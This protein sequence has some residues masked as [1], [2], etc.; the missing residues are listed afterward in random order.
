MSSAASRIDLVERIAI[1]LHDALDDR[2]I[3]TVHDPVNRT[4]IHPGWTGPV[5]W[6]L[7]EAVADTLLQCRSL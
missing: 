6:E 4:H 7:A 2:D 3:I 1:V 5:S